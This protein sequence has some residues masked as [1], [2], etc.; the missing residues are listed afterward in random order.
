MNNTEAIICILTSLLIGSIWSV[1]YYFLLTKFSVDKMASCT[2][3][4]WNENNKI[5]IVFNIFS[6]IFFNLLPIFIFIFTNYKIILFV[7]INLQFLI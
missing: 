3:I 5:S 1:I 7:S 6:V 4:K 2:E